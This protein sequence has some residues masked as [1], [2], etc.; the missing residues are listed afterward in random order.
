MINEITD[1]I[2]I[3][4]NNKLSL[5]DL[6][7]KIKIYED[8]NEKLQEARN[9]K[10]RLESKFVSSFD[11]M[12]KISDLQSGQSLSAGLFRISTL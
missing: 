2:T 1:K 4:N 12:E 7:E 9:K 6:K 3:T 11:M 10:E 5:V 8:N